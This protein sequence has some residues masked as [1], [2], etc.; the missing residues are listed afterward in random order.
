M[1]AFT[2]ARTAATPDELWLVEH[3][4]VFTMGLKGRNGTTQEIKNIPLVYSDRG[5]DITY[6]G[7]GQIVLY[8]MIDIVR[9]GIGIK[10]L[11]Q[12]LEQSALDYL[13]SQGITAERLAGAPGVYVGGK[14]IAS[15][16]LRVRRAS[17]YH[18]LALNVNMDLTPFTYI[19]PCGYRGMQVTQLAALGASIEP[20]Q[21]GDALAQ[22]FADLLGYNSPVILSPT[23]SAVRPLHG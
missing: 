13:A 1:R 14:K 22:R 20:G 12:T 18:G 10:R 2:D 17:S 15:L 7:P 9:L 16:G 23:H 4:P 5:G 21:A 6:H 11:V 8:A 3:P 19:D